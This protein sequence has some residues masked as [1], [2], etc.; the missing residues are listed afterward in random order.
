[1][2]NISV[3][4]SSILATFFLLDTVFAQTTIVVSKPQEKVTIALPNLCS[5]SISTGKAAKHVPLVVSEDLKLSGYFDVV[6]PSAYITSN[7]DC[8]GKVVS[9]YE[10]WKLINADFL[11]KGKTDNINGKLVIDFYL[12]D[13]ATGKSVL[14]RNYGLSLEDFDLAAHKIANEIVKYLTG[15]LGPFGSQIVYSSRVGRFKELFVTDLLGKNVRQLT[16]EKGLAVSPTW[17]NSGKL[18]LYTSYSRK[19]P[20]L[21]ILKFPEATV[22]SLTRTPE[23]EIGGDFA[24]DGSNVITSVSG[25]KDT[26][27]VIFN[28][29]GKLVKT[30]GRGNNS[31]DVSPSYSPDGTKV[32]FCSNRSGGPQ[33]YVLDL[34]SGREERISFVDSP[35]CTSPDWSPDSSKLAFVCRSDGGFQIYTSDSGGEGVS[36]LTFGGDNE[37]PSWSPDGRFLVFA[38]TFGKRFG[39]NLALLRLGDNRSLGEIKQL[40]FRTSDDTDP[41][42]GPVP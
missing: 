30:Y 14:G 39:F 29:L 8:S 36:Q 9:S 19:V 42:W 12:H 6:N 11:V 28:R 23:L 22:R 31:I 18:I 15:K 20:D 10:D 3:I 17:N 26:D 25:A 24:P 1:M 37:D 21:N 16:R 34:G 40:T 7:D 41:S 33:I 27:L 35:Y 4:F 13:V 38:S 5:T 2:I 32:A